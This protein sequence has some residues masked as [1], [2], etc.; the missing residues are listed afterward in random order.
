[1]NTT[2]ITIP[3]NEWSRP[4]QYLNMWNVLAFIV[5]HCEHRVIIIFKLLYVLVRKHMDVDEHEIILHLDTS[6]GSSTMNK[7]RTLNSPPPLVQHGKTTI[8]KVKRINVL[9]YVHIRLN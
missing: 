2:Y 3:L 6:K 8:N 9:I 7:P 1:M 5:R 4:T